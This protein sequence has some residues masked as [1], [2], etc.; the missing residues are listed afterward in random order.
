MPIILSSDNQKR[1]CL[2]IMHV[3]F[4]GYGNTSTLTRIICVSTNANK[5]H[6]LKVVTNKKKKV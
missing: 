3:H 2:N 6:K 4:C 5:R 1:K